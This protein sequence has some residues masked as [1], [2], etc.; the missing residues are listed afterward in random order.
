MYK[1]SIYLLLLLFLYSCNCNDNNRFFQNKLKPLDYFGV[2]QIKFR[3]TFDRMSQKI[4]FEN[5]QI[6]PIYAY[7]MFE[8]LLP[9]DTVIKKSGSLEHILK[10]NGETKIF[11]PKCNGKE[12]K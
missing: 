12:I 7:G 3:D 2:V 11:Y 10:R 1:K 8:E 4:R 5:G 9:G 6:I